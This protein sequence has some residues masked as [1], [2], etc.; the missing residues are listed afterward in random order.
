MI[1][2]PALAVEGGWLIPRLWLAPVTP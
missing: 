1:V 2:A